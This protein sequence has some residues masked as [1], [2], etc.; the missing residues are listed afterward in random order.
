MSNDFIEIYSVLC[1]FFQRQLMELDPREADDPIRHTSDE[2]RTLT[3]ALLERL[4]KEGI[5][6]GMGIRDR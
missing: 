4:R 6:I 2:A 5:V 3:N 1:D